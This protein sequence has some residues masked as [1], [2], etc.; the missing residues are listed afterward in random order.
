MTNEFTINKKSEQLQANFD[1]LA[2]IDNLRLRVSSSN[3]N[4]KNIQYVCG[5]FRS[6]NGLI[7]KN[8]Y[9]EACSFMEFL[10]NIVVRTL[11]VYYKFD[12]TVISNDTLKNE[13][14][15]TEDMCKK[16][17]TKYTD[18]FFEKNYH[19]VFKNENVVDTLIVSCRLVKRFADI[20]FEQVGLKQDSITSDEIQKF[21]EKY[22]EY[23]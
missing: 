14:T 10:F 23:K 9:N 20:Y 15:V 4:I 3:D 5:K 22:L 17:D 21:H 6:I 11:Y 8:L 12:N 16:I 19:R 7:E 13:F 18:N 2:E 1:L